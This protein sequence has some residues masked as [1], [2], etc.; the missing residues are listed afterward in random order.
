MSP[1]TRCM[2]RRKGP[3]V[4]SVCSVIGI[5]VSGSNESGG[6][7]GSG[8]SDWNYWRDWSG[9]N[10]WRDEDLKGQESRWSSMKPV[11]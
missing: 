4:N 1:V 7:G 5:G 3:R 10:Y 6:S 11:A 8:G 9:G 2:P